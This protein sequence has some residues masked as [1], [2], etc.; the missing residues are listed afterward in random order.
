MA[1]LPTYG[2]RRVWALLRRESDRDGQPVVNAKRV[3]RMCTHHLLLERK[4]ADNHRKQAHKG[5]VAVAE[6][7]RCW[8]SDGF[9]FRCDNGKKLRVTN[10]PYP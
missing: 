8:C 5:R 7:N 2:Y 6:S 10:S 9:E 1:D 3:Y 4:P